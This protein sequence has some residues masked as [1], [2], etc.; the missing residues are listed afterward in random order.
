MLQA[1][2][3]G[4]LLE[5]GQCH[6]GPDLLGECDINVSDHSGSGL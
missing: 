1:W 5:G 3:L 4:H 6:P 2:S